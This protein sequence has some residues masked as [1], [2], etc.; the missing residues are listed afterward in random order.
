MDRNLEVETVD[1]EELDEDWRD[2]IDVCAQHDRNIQEVMETAE[3]LQEI[4]DGR[5]GCV[6]MA[7]HCL[8]M[9]TQDLRYIKY[10]L[11]PA[12]PNADE[13]EKTEV[14]TNALPERYTAWIFITAITDR[15][16]PH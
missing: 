10:A 14:D 4:W 11:Y 1:D 12:G 2:N 7:R 13:F 16:C 8:N 3:K 5:L 6:D 9:T 15:T